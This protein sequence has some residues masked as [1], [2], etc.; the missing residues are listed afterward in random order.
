[1]GIREEVQTLPSYNIPMTVDAETRIFSSLLEHALIPL[2]ESKITNGIKD[3]IY[4]DARTY[5]KDLFIGV[6]ITDNLAVISCYDKSK[7]CFLQEIPDDCFHDLGR[8]HIA[9]LS[10]QIYTAIEEYVKSYNHQRQG[11]DD[12]HNCKPPL[13]VEGMRKHLDSLSESIDRL[14]ANK[15]IVYDKYPPIPEHFKE[16]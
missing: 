3:N 1:M 7:D 5:K 13:L 16:R 14:R 6:I 12:I 15:H 9:A 8:K 2:V 10:D 4:A 11:L